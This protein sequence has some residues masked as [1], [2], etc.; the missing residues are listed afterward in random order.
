GNLPA[1]I[2]SHHLLS[3]QIRKDILSWSKGL[4]L[5]GFSRARYPGVIVLEGEKKDVREF[6]TRLKSLSWKAL[7]V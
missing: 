1:L 2:C 6:I 7:Q 4:I 3:T 5:S